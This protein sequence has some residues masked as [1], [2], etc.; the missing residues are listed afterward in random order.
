MN[1]AGR[2]TI[3]QTNKIRNLFFIEKVD[4]DIISQMLVDDPSTVYTTTQKAKV[5]VFKILQKVDKKIVIERL[6]KWLSKTSDDLMT[7]EMMFSL[8]TPKEYKFNIENLMK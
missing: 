1:K 5:F 4:I 8:P 3:E 6:P 2:P 7:E